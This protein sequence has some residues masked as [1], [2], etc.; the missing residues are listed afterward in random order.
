MTANVLL[1]TRIVCDRVQRDA[2]RA[3]TPFLDRKSVV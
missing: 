1:I 3:S 2:L